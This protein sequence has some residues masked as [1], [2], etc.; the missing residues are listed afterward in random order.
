MPESQPFAVENVRE[1]GRLKELLGRLNDEDLSRG[2]GDGWTV[3]TLL[4]HLAFWDQRLLAVLSRWKK[5]GVGTCE[6][7]VDTV[8]EALRE[9]CAAMPPRAAAQLAVASAEAVD[10]FLEQAPLEF[11]E[12][13]GKIGPEWLLNR[14]LHRR[15][16]LDEIEGC[17]SEQANP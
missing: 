17:W 11:I 5:T 14:A 1:R 8:N 9:I 16:H 10:R 12:E 6:L 13:V 15:E 3:A 2:L 4:A 7:D